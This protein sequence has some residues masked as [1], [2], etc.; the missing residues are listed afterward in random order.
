MAIDFNRRGMGGNPFSKVFEKEPMISPPSFEYIPPEITEAVELRKEANDALSS[1]TDQYEADVADFKN[2][3]AT[4]KEQGIASL[5]QAPTREFRDD[6]VFRGESSNFFPP[7]DPI[8]PPMRPPEQPVIPDVYIPDVGTNPYQDIFNPYYEDE[9]DPR[10]DIYDDG[11]YDDGRYDDGGYDDSIYDDG[12]GG[13]TQDPPQDPPPPPSGPTNYYTGEVLVNP[14]QPYEQPSNQTNFNRAAMMS[15]KDFGT[16]PGFEPPPPPIL[17]KARK[18]PP[19]RPPHIM[20]QGMTMGGVL[21]N[22]ISQLPMNGQGDTLT[23]QVFQSGFRPR[24]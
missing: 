15:P 2:T 14:Y 4:E 1:A 3:L 18:V 19:K 12:V 5:P 21:N 16:T 22:G 23:T 7:E 8:I 13:G 10:E 9:Y 20:P 11:Y 24:R 17:E 6:R